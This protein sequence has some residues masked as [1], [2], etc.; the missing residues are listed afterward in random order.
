MEDSPTECRWYVLREVP[1][2]SDPDWYPDSPSDLYHE[3]PCGEATLPGRGFC[4]LHAGA[5]DMDGL[6]FEALVD[7]GH[8]WS[9]DYR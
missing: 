4:A 2:A 7:S 9:N 6:E 8:S 1:W 3:V 5:M